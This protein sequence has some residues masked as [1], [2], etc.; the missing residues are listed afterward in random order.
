MLLLLLC[1][2]II[3][4]GQTQPYGQIDIADLKLTTCDFEK[5][6]SAMVLFDK[7]EV[8]TEYLSTTVSVHRRIKILNDKGSDEANISIEYYGKDNFE[9]I[10]DIQAQTINLDNHVIKDIPVNPAQVFKQTVDKYTKKISFSFPAVKAGSVIEYIYTLTM[11]YEGGFP[12][13]N[14]QGSLPVRYSEFSAKIIKDFIYA[15]KPRVYTDYVKN[16]KEPMLDGS[17]YTL[18]NKYVWAVKN[19]PSFRDEPFSTGF[20]DNVQGIKFVLS[21]IQHDTHPAYRARITTWGRLASEILGDPDFGDQLTKNLNDDEN[22]VAAAKL[23]PTDDQRISYIL[24]KVRAAMKWN[25]KDRW[26]AV[27][28]VKKAWDRKLG[29][30]AEI[31]MILYTFLRQAGIKCTVVVASTR[32][33][34]KFDL[35]LPDLQDF[36][37]IVL[38][39]VAGNK[40]VILDAIDKFTPV[41]AIPFDLLNCQA[42]WLD[43]VSQSFH[44][45]D[46]KNLKPSRQAI[47]VNAQVKPDGKLEGTAR[48]SRFSYDR[49]GGLSRFE[50]LGETKYKN[51]L[52]NGN[53][54]LK[55]LSFNRENVE[56]DTLPLIESAAF[57]LDVSAGDDKYLFINPNLF[58]TLHSNPFLSES[59]NA[60]IDFGSN[61]IYSIKG[62]Y[63]IPAGYKM[64]SIPEG[65]SLTMPDTSISFKRVVSEEDGSIL[66]NYFIDFNRSEFSADEYPAI[67]DFYKKM[68]EMLN[69]QI[70]L[71][72]I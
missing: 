13:W 48:I 56:N 28:G 53:N 61:N 21:L 54:N 58:T 72:K 33:H 30:N 36:N 16:T 22:I 62:L 29:N 60:S 27:D 26:F 1:A 68:Y 66:V 25:G 57:R 34:G 52:I 37:K 12:D 67:H 3:L 59:R 70:V 38:N 6:A 41:G 11:D 2:A 65:L 18:G 42:L 20:A 35:A 8:N 51:E 50:K 15:I 32:D 47:F 17:N 63:K 49:A 44:I 4:K 64:E 39:A 14:F 69:E 45:G 24:G 46:L 23:L 55:I 71:K 10:S 7:I 9:H 40:A 5:G 19:V 31:N 43:P